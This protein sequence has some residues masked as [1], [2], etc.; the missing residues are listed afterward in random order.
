MKYLYYADWSGGSLVAKSIPELVKRIKDK[1]K[2]IETEVTKP[3]GTWTKEDV[4]IQNRIFLYPEYLKNNVFNRKGDRMG[5]VIHLLK[6]ESMNI[7]GT[8]EELY[9]SRMTI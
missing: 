1:F 9:I 6:G 5:K 4:C 2:Y 3:A 8:W 7:I